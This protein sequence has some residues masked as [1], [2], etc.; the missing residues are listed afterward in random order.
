M[1]ALFEGTLGA[2]FKGTLG[3]LSEGTLED[4]GYIRF[5]SLIS[6]ICLQSTGVKEVKKVVQIYTCQK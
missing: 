6:N 5:F 4:S 2:P 3:A 1:R